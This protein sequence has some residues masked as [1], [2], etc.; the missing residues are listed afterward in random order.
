MRRSARDETYAR[1]TARVLKPAPDRAG[2]P[3][4]RPGSPRPTHPSDVPAF[5][6]SAGNAAV[7]AVIQRMQAPGDKRKRSGSP[8]GQ[9]PSKQ[10]REAASSSSDVETSSEEEVEDPFSARNVHQLGNEQDRLTGLLEQMDEK[11]APE[12]IKQTV[13]DKLAILSL[14][15]NLA[16]MRS[17]ETVHEAIRL[18][19][20]KPDS[21]A[22]SKYLAKLDDQLTFLAEELP[23]AGPPSAKTLQDMWPQ[24]AP[25]F[26]SGGQVGQ[27]GCEDRAHAICLAIAQRSPAIAAHQLSKQWA[28]SSGARLNASHQWNHHV[29]ASV[30][31]T[32]GVMVIDPIFSRSGPIELSQWINRVQV[33][34]RNVHQTAWGFLGKPGP[35]NKPDENSAVEYV[36]MS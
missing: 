8:E 15:R 9:E 3:T 31:T 35:D 26:G 14:L 13:V 23:S 12:H 34:R 21:P 30:T 32:D 20:R 36:P 27:D 25:A 24:L 1:G 6:G 7:N 4:A 18:V 33:D 22:K 10:V 2:H 19:S 28:T 17:V 29:A 16:P 5:G 11:G